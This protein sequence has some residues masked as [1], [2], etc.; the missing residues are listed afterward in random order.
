MY[1]IQSVF[2]IYGDKLGTNLRIFLYPL[3][4]FRLGRSSD[5]EICHRG[6]PGWSVPLPGASAAARAAPGCGRRMAE[7]TA[8]SAS[9]SGSSLYRQ[10]NQHLSNCKIGKT[11]VDFHNFGTVYNIFLGKSAISPIAMSMSI[12]L[13]A[14]E[15]LLVNTCSIIAKI[16]N[17]KI[18]FVDF[19]ICRQMASLR[20]LFFDFDLCFEG[21]KLKPLISLKRLDLA[22]K[23]VG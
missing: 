10:Q 19:D 18:M 5:W 23:C 14:Y 9:T 4:A 16:K 3:A 7:D 8:R 22:H 12:S 17:E 2:G 15:L 1:K 20:K 11:F 13:T 6:H 21:K